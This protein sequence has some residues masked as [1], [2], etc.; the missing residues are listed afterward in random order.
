MQFRSVF[1]TASHQ[2]AAEAKNASSNNFSQ[3]QRVCFRHAK[4]E[5]P[6]EVRNSR[7][8]GHLQKES[9]S[10]PE[11]PD[12]GTKPEPWR[13]PWRHQKAQQHLSLKDKLIT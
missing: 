9:A 8:H 10:S 4:K 11:A 12:D 7:L 5:G 2:S 6:T 3:H 13:R 1:T